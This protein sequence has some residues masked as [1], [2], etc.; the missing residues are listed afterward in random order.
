MILG[1][2]TDNVFMFFKNRKILASKKMKHFIF[3]CFEP[4][5]AAKANEI[6]VFFRFRAKFGTKKIKIFD[7]FMF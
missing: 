6:I 5:L 7:C 2:E 4:N 3:S 1:N